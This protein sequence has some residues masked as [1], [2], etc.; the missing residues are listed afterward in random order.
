MQSLREIL[1]L[2]S[3]QVLDQMSIGY[4]ISGH[5]ILIFTAPTSSCCGSH[6][7]HP[8]VTSRGV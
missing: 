7:C 3:H 8:A 2:P 1:Q 5:S 4:F 6:F